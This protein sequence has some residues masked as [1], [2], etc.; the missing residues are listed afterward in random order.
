MIWIIILII[1]TLLV[2]YVFRQT[3]ILLTYSILI[4]ISSILPTKVKVYFF[5]KAYKYIL[6]NCIDDW[7]E[8][9]EKELKRTNEFDFVTIEKLKKELDILLTQKKIINKLYNRLKKWS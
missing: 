5:M 3:I 7:I 9:K 6:D 1:L 8:L 4:T 2:L